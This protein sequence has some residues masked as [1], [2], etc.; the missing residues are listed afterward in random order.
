MQ[1]RELLEREDELAAVERALTAGRE[2]RGAVL[3][4]EAPPGTGKSRLCAEAAELGRAAGLTVRTARATELQRSIPFGVAEQLLGSSARSGGEAPEEPLA[5][6]GPALVEELAHGLEQRLFAGDAEA[7]GNGEVGAS[8]SPH[9]L[10]VDDAQ[11]IDGASATF[12]SHLAVRIDGLPLALVVAARSDRGDGAALLDELLAVDGAELLEP[13]PLSDASVGRLVRDRLGGRAASASLDA[14]AAACAR[15]SGGNPF[16]LTELLREL[17][18][19]DANVPAAAIAEMAPPSV[20]RALIARLGQLGPDARELAPAVAIFERCELEHAAALAGL[21]LDAAEQAADALAGA[22][23]LEPGEPL[24][25]SHPLIASA[26]R[27]DMGAFARARAHAQ[28]AR[29]LADAGAPAETIASQLLHARPAAD[30]EVAAR[31]REAGRSAASRGEAELAARLLDRA[32]REGAAESGPSAR[33]ATLVELAEVEARIGS[34][35]AE[36]HLAQALEELESAPERARAAIALARTLHHAGRF[37]NAAEVIEAQLR[38][39]G[40]GPPDPGMEELEGELLGAWISSA[41]LHPPLRPRLA[42][43]MAPLRDRAAAG[44]LPTDPTICALLA[45][46]MSSTD[47]DPDLVRR[48]ALAA[49]DR[50]PL[51]NGDSRGAALGYAAYALLEVDALAELMPLLDAAEFAASERGTAIALSIARHMRAIARF[52]SGDLEGAIADAELSLEVHRFGWEPSPWSTPILALAHIAR[53]D[54]AAAQDAIAVGENAGGERADTVLLLEARAALRLA[55]RRPAEALADARAAGEIAD[56]MFGVKSSRGFDWTRLAALAADA[57]GRAE[58]AHELAEEALRRGRHSGVARSHGRALTA[59]GMIDGRDRGEALLEE[60]VEVL[61]A[62]PSRLHRAIALLELG[63]VRRRRGRRQ[64]AEEP[65][66]EALELAEGFGAL[67]IV[68]RA[69]VELNVLGRRPR[70]GARTGAG[71]LTPSERRVAE[72]AAAGLSTPE[73]AH[74]LYVT[75]KTVESHLGQAYRKLEIGGRRELEGALSG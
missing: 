68:K 14:I 26:L 24:Q 59:A 3:V 16:Y 49:F 45:P 66:F 23:L 53:G 17:E 30:P 38:D 48:V 44:E 51:V 52:H 37:G 58:E 73:I 2:G 75:R 31:L 50:D 46:W 12:L 28:A 60:A 8:P 39:L 64:A 15:A 29:I 41:I 63:A 27:A 6:R 67:P 42:E 22:A 25:L 13:E 9:L 69:R 55:E 33:A 10:V 70:R 43:T 1:D 47:E 40:A 19:G 65:L 54:L 7:P 74:R 71:A 34:E 21:G 4:I 62:S 35:Q 20:M 32:L 72:L 56:D 36:V 61:G 11:W 18:A 5:D 57:D